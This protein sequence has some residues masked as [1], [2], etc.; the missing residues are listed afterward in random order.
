MRIAAC[1]CSTLGVR[2]RRTVPEHGPG[3]GVQPASRARRPE[4]GSA[5]REGVV[6]PVRA[7]EL[8]AGAV[9]ARV[10]AVAGA[11]DA[12][13]E[14]HDQKDDGGHALTMPSRDYQHK[15]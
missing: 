8:A 11:E 10:D 7:L 1:S 4:A 6:R 2:R 15:S 5:G 9:E 13:D 14:E 12:D 3:G